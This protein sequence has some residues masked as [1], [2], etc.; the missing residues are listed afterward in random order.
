MRISLAALFLA[1]AIPWQLQAAIPPKKAYL[2]FPVR[3]QLQQEFYFNHKEQFYL[4]VHGDSLI[5]GDGAATT[6][7]IQNVNFISEAH[8][9][10]ISR[11]GHRDG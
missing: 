1:A 9:D 10:I 11:T 6:S 2:L 5:D 3:T 8:P 7:V 4:L